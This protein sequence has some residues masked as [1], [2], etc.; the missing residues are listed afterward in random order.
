MFRET[1]YEIF[2]IKGFEPYLEK[3]NPNFKVREEQNKLVYDVLNSFNSGKKHILM[4]APTGTGK[5]FVYTYISL[6]EYIIK[7]VNYSNK[8][9]EEN[10][11]DLKKFDKVLNKNRI[12]I[13]TNNKSLQKQVYEDMLN[14]I[15]PS[16]ES[17]FEFKG[18]DKHKDMLKKLKV[19]IYKSK[20]NYL[21]K[22]SFDNDKNKDENFKLDIEKEMEIQGTPSIDYDLVDRYDSNGKLKY[23]SKLFDKYNAKDRNCKNCKIKECKFNKSK[24]EV[25]NIMITNYDYL[26]LLSKKVNLEYIHTLILDEVHNLPNKLINISSDEFNLD[27]FLFRLP[28]I[29]SKFN[30]EFISHLGK[31]LGYFKSFKTDKP[32]FSDTELFNLTYGISQN[33]KNI[34]DYRNKKLNIQRTKMIL[35]VEKN[36]TIE[37]LRNIYFKELDKLILEYEDR[38]F[39]NLDKILEEIRKDSKSYMN[40]G[41]ILSDYDKFI[42]FKD[43]N[44]MSDYIKNKK[45]EITT[46]LTDNNIDELDKI[47][48][49]NKEVKS[50]YDECKNLVY[51][52]N[53]LDIYSRITNEMKYYIF[54]LKDLINKLDNN[55]FEVKRRLV[56][57]VI[58]VS[59]DGNL[60]VNLYLMND[61]T[62]NAYNKFLNTINKVKH[63]VYCSA[64][65]SI[66]G[67]YSFFVSRLGLLEDE[68]YRCYIPNS[69]FDKYNKRYIFLDKNYCLDRYGKET[70]YKW[71]L[72]KKL[73][74]IV[75]NGDSG[76]LILCTSKIDVDNAY[77]CLKDNLIGNKY[78]IHSQYYSSLPTIMQDMNKNKDNNTIVIGNTGFWEGID[79]K[80]DNMTTL[81]ITKL[82]YMRVNEPSIISKFNRLLFDK[83][84]YDKENSFISEYWDF[85]NNM[86]KIVFYQGVGRLIRSVTD[87]GVIVCLF[88][89]DNF[90]KKFNVITDKHLGIDDGIVLEAFDLNILENLIQSSIKTTKQNREK[91]LK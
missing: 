3:Y 48:S 47:F 5:T 80:G 67:D 24:K 33:E 54:Y 23:D 7:M 68:T 52:L 60:K 42:S 79:F 31:L 88:S 55:S 71:L 25:H 51:S 38:F 43:V 35:N 22:K 26:L 76:S 86:M 14:V 45:G 17:Y 70:R 10:N 49:N 6:I 37:H 69:P 4:E 72:D 73:D 20:S 89:Y 11:D 56:P 46:N 91:Y 39:D 90:I 77:N 63:I 27:N 81:I 74:S 8:L 85:Y 19:G 12:V 9:E 40:K 83:I 41:V 30:N 50:L 84:E 2:G 13:V 58:T 1:V 16:L 21:C 75:T 65:M 29:K 61:D 64:T 66:E 34:E 62:V 78:S 82:P 53:N 28:K 32:K 59:I 18:L 36:K 15:I 44:G 57:D 87:Y